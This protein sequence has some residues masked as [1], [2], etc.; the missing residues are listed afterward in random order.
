MAG[1]YDAN[2]GAG[3]TVW[4]QFWSRDTGF[5]APNNVGLTSAIRLAIL[6]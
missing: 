2:L 6:P 5:A 3:T 1:G 4:G